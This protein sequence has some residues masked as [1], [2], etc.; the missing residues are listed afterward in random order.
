MF[1]LVPFGNRRNALSKKDGVWD[2]RSLFDDF[3]GD[4]V[5]PAFVSS[6]SAM[7]ADVKENE[8]EYILEMEMPGVS[9]DNIT[10]DLKDDILTVAVNEEEEKKEE[11]D[12][13]IMRERR[14]GSYCRRFYLDN[15]KNDA[16]E[17]KY[18]S[19]ILTV[20]LPKEDGKSK[21]TNIQVN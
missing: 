8:K 18:E 5:Y 9:K 3:F 12:N 1:D 7:R 2:L 19:G 4:S 15:V 10:L 14:T 6:G 20:R 16:V 17:A 21:S 13:Y 11:K